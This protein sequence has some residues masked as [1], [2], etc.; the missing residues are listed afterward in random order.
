MAVRL[1][2]R[3]RAVLRACRVA[4][5]GR[6]WHHLLELSSSLGCASSSFDHEQRDGWLW[7]CI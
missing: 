7:I 1:R 3:S 4:R 6:D 5:N 2:G